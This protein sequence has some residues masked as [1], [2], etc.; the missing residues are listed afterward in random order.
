MMSKFPGSDHSCRRR[1]VNKLLAERKKKNKK[2][3]IYICE[4]VCDAVREWSE[5]TRPS[6]DCQTTIFRRFKQLEIF[7]KKVAERSRDS[8]RR[9][10]DRRPTVKQRF[11]DVSSDLGKFWKKSLNGHATVVGGHAT[12]GRLSNNVFGRFKRFGKILKKV[13]ERSRDSGWGH[14]TVGRLSNN[15]FWTFQA[16]RKKIL[17][18]VAERSRDS[19][20]RSRDRR[21]T[22]KQR[23]WTF[24][25]IRK[26]FVKTHRR[27]TRQWSVVTRLSADCQAHMCMYIIINERERDSERARERDRER[28]RERPNSKIKQKKIT[29]T[30]FPFVDS[31]SISLGFSR[32]S[33]AADTWYYVAYVH[34]GELVPLMG[35]QR[36]GIFSPKSKILFV[37][38]LALIWCRNFQDRTIPVG[39]DTWTSFWRKEEKK[40]KKN[41]EIYICEA[42]CDAVLEWSEVTRPSADCQTTIFRRFKHIR[43]FFFKVAERSRDSGRRSRDCRPTVK[44]RFFE[45]SSN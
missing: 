9:S 27:V 21:L 30:I 45:I 36:V 23:F 3:E 44:Q 37:L 1:Y 42:V 31:G 19:G 33:P 15:V 29:P 4:A 6:A 26:L 32:E 2:N 35:N 34:N 38:S 28:E 17:K 20:R 12:V 40:K 5:V 22:V 39:G 10:R 25:A 13:A 16:I 24:Q 41:S 7:L 14:A 8:G 11:L 18:K 43:N